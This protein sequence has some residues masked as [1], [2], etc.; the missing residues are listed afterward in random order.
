LDL[1][2]FGSFGSRST[3]L[4][5]TAFNP[6]LSH[7]KYGK[8]KRRSDFVPLLIL[9]VVNYFILFLKISGNGIS[10]LI[11]GMKI[12]RSNPGNRQF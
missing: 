10:G 9:I 12:A 7:L 6:P 8:L 11:S 1:D 5:K 2:P 3:P 4:A